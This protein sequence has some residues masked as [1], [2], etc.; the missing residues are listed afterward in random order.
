M[1]LFISQIIKAAME[2]YETVQEETPWPTPSTS[3]NKQFENEEQ[4]II[5][6][7]ASTDA[8]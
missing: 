2:E 8:Q 6:S 5:E 7:I 4:D 3:A 1:F